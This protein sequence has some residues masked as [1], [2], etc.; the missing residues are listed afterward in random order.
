MLRDEQKIAVDLAKEAGKI[1]LKYYHADYRVDMKKEDEPVTQAD[2]ASN[3]FITSQ[4]HEIFPE[5]GILAEES[6]DDL[7]RLQKRRIW[8]V[9]PMDGT[10][11]FIDKI[12]EFSVMIGLVEDE[13]PILGV[14]FQPTT[15]TL[16]TA[17]KGLGAYVSQNGDQRRLKVS[18]INIIPQMTMV[19]SRSHRAKLVDKMKHALGLEK[20]V[21]SGSVGLK[22]GLMV[23]TK[24]D[25]YLHPNSKTK[26]WDTC[27]PQMILQ[28]AGG[29]ITDC[30]GEPL[31]YNKEDVYN[32]KGFVASNG[33]CHRQVLETI[34]PHLNELT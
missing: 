13:Q 22:V 10:R 5:D 32:S 18:D 24:C 2:R 6:K 14:V 8:L 21:S 4:L 17:V 3:E 7:T 23:E 25:L 31:R 19:V 20:E 11:E 28:E 15:G 34:R 9:D 16:Y 30:W 29:Q 27:A 26:E 33:R 1:V 12:G